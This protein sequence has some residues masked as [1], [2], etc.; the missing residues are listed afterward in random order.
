MTRVVVVRHYDAEADPSYAERALRLLLASDPQET[1]DDRP[2]R[3]GVKAG[4]RLATSGPAATTK[5]G[6][7]A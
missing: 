7:A 1:N 3:E 5:N 4:E 2:E 6:E